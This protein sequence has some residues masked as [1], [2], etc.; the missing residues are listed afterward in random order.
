MLQFSQSCCCPSGFC[1]LFVSI[2]RP[3]CTAGFFPLS[4][5]RLGL[6]LPSAALSRW[7]SSRSLLQSFLHII[8]KTSDG[9]VSTHA[10]WSSIGFRPGARDHP[11]HLPA[12]R[13][14]HSDKTERAGSE[15]PV[16]YR[17]GIPYIINIHH[18]RSR[19]M[20]TIPFFLPQKK[21]YSMKSFPSGGIHTK[22]VY[23]PVS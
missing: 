2:R 19:I 13:P 22:I 14:L 20:D 7:L 5:A 1:L 3:A 23:R 11:E 8:R 10:Q 15:K 16:T 9:V 17:E 4:H 18:S 12:R 21:K 6:T